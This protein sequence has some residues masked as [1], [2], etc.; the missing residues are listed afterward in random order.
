[1]VVLATRAIVNCPLLFRIEERVELLVSVG[2]PVSTGQNSVTGLVLVGAPLRHSCVL[3]PRPR[4]WG[5]GT[6]HQF[7][8]ISIETNDKKIKDT[9][10]TT[11]CLSPSSPSL[12]SEIDLFAPSGSVFCCDS[13]SCLLW[14]KTLKKTLQ[15]MNKALDERRTTTFSATS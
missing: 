14:R 10:S 12:V 13:L 6:P 15:D 5:R 2:A 4:F 9:I 3:I 1:M 7:G 8:G 11:M